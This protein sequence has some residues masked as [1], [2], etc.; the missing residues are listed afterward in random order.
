MPRFSSIRRALLP[1]GPL[2][3]AHRCSLEGSV[4]GPPPSGF[5]VE[6]L[7]LFVSC[8]VVLSILSS[9][10]CCRR[11]ATSWRLALFCHCSASRIFIILAGV[12]GEAS[13]GP[14]FHMGW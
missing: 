13:R 10:C 12:E 5:T 6:E 7:T 1:S 4:L 8:T 14:A 9:S 3:G 2:D 11:S